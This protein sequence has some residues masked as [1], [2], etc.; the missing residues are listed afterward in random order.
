MSGVTRTYCLR[1][2]MRKWDTYSLTVYAAC[3]MVQIVDESYVVG[4]VKWGWRGWR[5]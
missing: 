1:I 5:V 4:L 3:T 2:L